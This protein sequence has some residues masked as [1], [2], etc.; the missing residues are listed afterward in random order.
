[1]EILLKNIEGK[2]VLTLIHS[3][4]KH[5]KD[6]GHY[7]SRGSGW[8]WALWNLKAHLEGRKTSSYEDWLKN[9]NR[10]MRHQKM[11]GE[12]AVT[13]EKVNLA[14][15]FSLFQEYWSPLASDSP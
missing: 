12:E 11:Y 13:M 9:R 4:F 1:M 14:Q 8:N 10:L 5:K 6:L 15:K 2:T 7:S 3:G